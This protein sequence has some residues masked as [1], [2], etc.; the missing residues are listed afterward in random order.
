MENTSNQIYTFQFGLLCTSSFLFFAS[1]SMILPELPAYLSDMGGGQ[2]IGFIISLFTLAALI[3]RPFSGKLADTIGRR[4][5]IYFGVVTSFICS[6][7]YPILTGV[8]AF[9]L[10]RFFHGFSTGFT[11]TGTSA[12]V[13][14]IIPPNRRGEAMGI[15]GLTSNIGT[16]IGPALGSEITVA[17]SIDF[18]FYTAAGFAILSMLILLGLKETLT[19]KQPFRLELLKIKR[20]EIIEPRVAD[21][22]ITMFLMVVALGV[23]LTVVPDLSEYHQMRNKGVFFTFYTVSSLLIRFLAGKI[24]DKYGRVIV[25][26]W[27]AVVLMISMIYMGYAP[28]ATHLLAAAVIYGVAVG[29]ASPTI[30]AWTI[31]L[32]HPEKLGKAMATVY[33]AL[34]AGI[35]LAAIGAGWLYAQD[36]DR[37]P[38]TFF[39]PAFAAFI[40]FIYLQFGIK[41]KKMEKTYSS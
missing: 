17:S 37:I 25:I 8:S 24:S 11:P 19:D 18:M 12:Y 4:P 7:L 32:A 39:L 14:D 38:M 1:F 40:A 26:K 41:K 34:E 13:A 9:L 20:D 23:V 10:L 5:I 15:L 6:L 29:L 2:Y 36:I 21:A 33:I 35:G 30:F 28:N 22:A 16:A 27:G 3:S 31:D